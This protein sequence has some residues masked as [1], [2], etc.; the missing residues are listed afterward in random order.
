HISIRHPCKWTFDA[1]PSPGSKS[2]KPKG[3]VRRRSEN[4]RG[5]FEE[6]G[7][8]E[9]QVEPGVG[10]RPLSG[11]APVVLRKGH[12]PP[13]WADKVQSFQERRFRWNIGSI[14]K[15]ASFEAVNVAAIRSRCDPPVQMVETPVFH[16]E[17]EISGGSLQVRVAEHEKQYAGASRNK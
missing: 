5:V 9:A 16:E 7:F 4:C 6:S 8:G 2:S 17:R 14:I 3:R 13:G 12:H 15:D 10:A 11:N 1:T